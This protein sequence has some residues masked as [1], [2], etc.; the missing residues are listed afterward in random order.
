MSK[1]NNEEARGFAV[2]TAKQLELVILRMSKSGST[3]ADMVVT[4]YYENVSDFLR[5]WG[6]GLTFCK[7]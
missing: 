5:M 4:Y 7:L 1:E 3:T 6:G 2:E